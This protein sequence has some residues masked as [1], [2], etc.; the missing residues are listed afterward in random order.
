MR[1]VIPLIPPLKSTLCIIA[2]ILPLLSRHHHISSYL[3]FVS[4]HKSFHC[5]KDRLCHWKTLFLARSTLCKKYFNA[6]YQ[7]QD[8]RLL[9]VSH[10][11][12]QRFM[13]RAVEYSSPYGFTMA[14]WDWMLREESERYSTSHS[15]MPRSII[16]LRMGHLEGKYIILCN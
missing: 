3:F 8:S 7:S 9:S 16:F 5:F 10:L 13:N 14:S 12:R 1:D 15:T 4:L 2:C 11:C 6:E